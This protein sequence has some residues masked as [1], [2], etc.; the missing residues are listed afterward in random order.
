MQQVGPVAWCDQLHCSDLSLR[1][2]P[3]HRSSSRCAWKT[4]SLHVMG[5]SAAIS[6]YKRDNGSVEC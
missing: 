4:L 5:F 2:G 1:E 6:D 3:W